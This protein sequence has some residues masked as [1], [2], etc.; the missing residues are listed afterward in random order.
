MF[1]A[2]EIKTLMDSLL[3]LL[4]LFLFGSDD[5]YL[6]QAFIGALIGAGISI[7]GGIISSQK[8]KKAK[9]RQQAELD[10]QK[11]SNE[12]WYNRRYNEDYTQ[13]ATAQALLTKARQYADDTYKR[14][15]GAAKV[16]GASTESAALAKQA[17]D[18]VISDVM[19]NIAAQGD[20][21]KDNIELQYMQ[22]K[23]AYANQQMQMYQQQAQNSIA[24]G[25]SILQAGMG[26]AGADIM[27][28]LNSGK[29]LFDN[30]FKKNNITKPMYT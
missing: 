10:A 13:T 21:R 20:A 29:G 6:Q 1:V 18:K 17:G 3:D 16:G 22:N 14:A 23:N 25:N 19:G 2:I 5:P 4:K 8:A 12:N 28:H 27:S 15:A 26:M 24:A 11:S 9:K 30:L 7:A